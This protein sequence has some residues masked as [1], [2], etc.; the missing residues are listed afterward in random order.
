MAYLT[1]AQLR[2]VLNPDGDNTDT[3]SAAGMTD[4]EL[5]EAI[6]DAQAEVDGKLSAR[7][8]TPL[9]TPLP[10]LIFRVVRDIAAYLATLTNRRG[11]PLT[12]S[13][14]IAL[15]Y[16]AAEQLLNGLAAGTVPLP[17]EVAPSQNATQNAVAVNGYDGTLLDGSD[18]GWRRVPG[19]WTPPR[20]VSGWE[21]IFDRYGGW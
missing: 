2:L 10:T 9:V 20:E 17:P 12:P 6:N 5:Q 14:P 21:S 16:A 13:D 1:P 4:P 3:G 8:S 15:R 19:G 18:A 11:D 7:T